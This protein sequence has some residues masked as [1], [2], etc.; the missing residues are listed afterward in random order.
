MS[1]LTKDEITEWM[2]MEMLEHDLFNVGFCW[3]NSR[4]YIGFC[5]VNSETY[6]PTKIELSEF[7]FNAMKDKFRMVDVGLHELAHALAY[8]D[9]GKD[10]D[11]HGDIWKAYCL[12]VGAEPTRCEHRDSFDQSAFKYTGYC[13]NEE[14]DTAYGFSRLG[15]R[16][17]RNWMASPD[18]YWCPDCNFLLKVSKNFQYQN[19]IYSNINEVYNTSMNDNWNSESLAGLIIMG[20][21]LMLALSGLV[22]LTVL[23]NN[24]L[25][26]YMW[27]PGFILMICGFWVVISK[28]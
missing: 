7:Y 6:Q 3:G 11:A 27:I 20:I 9:H 14:C 8:R 15:T 16:W 19:T 12:Q 23:E 25:L 28:D 17:K 4:T 2:L 26:S 24:T 13:P 10:A 18:G 22:D 5:S 21:G 1:E